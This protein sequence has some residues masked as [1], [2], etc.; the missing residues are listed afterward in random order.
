VNP[1]I[2][3]KRRVARLNRCTSKE[4]VFELV[5]KY[6][7]TR[8]EMHRAETCPIAQYLKKGIDI[9][10]GRILVGAFAANFIRPD[11]STNRYI[12]NTPVQAALQKLDSR[13][14]VAKG[15]K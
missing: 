14:H 5:K 6:P 4:E 10:D 1:E 15:S 11:E 7:N 13:V 12:L 8:D 3:F 2:A 9:L